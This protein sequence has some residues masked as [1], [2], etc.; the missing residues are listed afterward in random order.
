MTG[1]NPLIFA[2][3]TIALIAGF[4]I[5]RITELSGYV[6]MF[7][8]V[9]VRCLMFFNIIWSFFLLV[10][11]TYFKYFSMSSCQ[12]DLKGLWRCSFHV[13]SFCLIKVSKFIWERILRSRRLK[14]WLQYAIIKIVY[15]KEM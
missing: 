15:N 14:W 6:T 11:N 4:A 8:I 2:R 9:T 3:F 1:A 7:P 12:C 10:F 5:S 13:L